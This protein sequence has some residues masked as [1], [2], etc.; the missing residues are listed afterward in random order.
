MNYDE[1]KKLA[2]S[3]F[4]SATNEIINRDS[5]SSVQLMIIDF[6]VRDAVMTGYK[7]GLDEGLQIGLSTI[8]HFDEEMS[9]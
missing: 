7:S 2:Q 8:K 3:E 9:K 1:A 6:A 5:F 4:A